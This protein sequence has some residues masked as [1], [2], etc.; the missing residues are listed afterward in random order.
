VTPPPPA[1][2]TQPPATRTPPA[3]TQPPPTTQPPPAPIRSQAAVNV[4]G[5]WLL[6]DTVT[7]GQVVGLAIPFRISLQQQGNQIFGQGDGLRLSGMISGLT[8]AVNYVQDGG[9]TGTFEWTLDPSGSTFDGAFTNSIGNGGSSSGQRLSAGY[10]ASET[11]VLDSHT[12][13][14]DKS[15]GKK[16]EH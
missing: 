11:S 7:Y 16:T 4:T 5:S 14:G 1:R 10:L 9:A 15:K 12:A 2:E 13:N 3:A 6:T 8:I